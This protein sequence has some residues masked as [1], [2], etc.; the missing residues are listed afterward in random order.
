[1]TEFEK[2]VKAFEQE[3][4][5][6]EHNPSSKLDVVDSF[7]AAL[8]AVDKITPEISEYL[9]KRQDDFNGEYSRGEF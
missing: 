7:F 9:N 2:V 8:R 5:V 3:I 1:M 4:E 6:N